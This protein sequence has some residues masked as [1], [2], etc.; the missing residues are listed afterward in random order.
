MKASTGQAQDS[1]PSQCWLV[2]GCFVSSLPPLILVP[3][4]PQVILTSEEAAHG[5]APLFLTRVL[6][7]EN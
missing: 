2:L 5:K 6:I 7:S 3:G 4:H 1:F